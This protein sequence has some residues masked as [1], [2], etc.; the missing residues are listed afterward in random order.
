MNEEYIQLPNRGDHKCFGCSPV[1]TS[2]LQMTFYTNEGAVYS[3][4]VVP[5]H[6]CGW[7]NLVHGGVLTT[8]MDE[9]MSWAAIYLLKQVPMTKSISVDFNKPVYVGN[10]LKA[11]GTVLD[12]KG[13]HEVLMAGRIY[14][15]DE[16]CCA[17]ATG[18][19]AVFSPAVAKRLS[20]ADSESLKWFEEI[21]ELK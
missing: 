21:F 3:N 4:L 7:N 19:F 10:P 14:N 5:D 6:L 13:K 9:I 8:I 2:G 1:N 11:E 20:I 12:K 18:T 16:V 15:T 17:S